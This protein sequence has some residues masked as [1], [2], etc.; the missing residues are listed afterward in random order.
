MFKNKN[1]FLCNRS[2]RKK[3]CIGKRERSYCLRG[4]NGM[5]LNYRH[6]GDAFIIDKISLSGNR[7]KLSSVTDR[8]A[9]LQHSSTNFTSK[10]FSS[11]VT[12]FQDNHKVS[13]SVIFLN[14]YQN[15]MDILNRLQ[16]RIEFT[17][18]SV[19]GDIPVSKPSPIPSA[20]QMVCTSD[21]LSFPSE[22]NVSK[23]LDQKAELDSE[24]VLKFFEPEFLQ[25]IQNSEHESKAI[26]DIS[27]LS[28]SAIEINN[29]NCEDYINCMAVQQ[30]LKQVAGRSEFLTE[31]E[32]NEAVRKTTQFFLNFNVQEQNKEKGSKCPASDR[33]GEPSKLIVEN[34]D[35]SLM[36]TMHC[37]SVT[38]S[39]SIHSKIIDI[40]N[41]H[42]VNSCVSS[43]CIPV[44][45]DESDWNSECKSNKHVQKDSET[46]DLSTELI[47]SALTSDSTICGTKDITIDGDDSDSEP[48]FKFNSDVSEMHSKNKIN[49]VENTI[50]HD[51]A[52]GTR[53][54]KN[55]LVH[56][57]CVSF[58]IPVD[59]DNESD[60]E[61][62]SID[63][64][65]DV[66]NMSTE[67]KT[68]AVNVTHKP[69]NAPVRSFFFR[70]DSSSS[71][72][73]S[74][75]DDD[76]D[77]DESCNVE[78]VDDVSEFE[79][80]G[81]YV[82]NFTMQRADASAFTVNP[83][84]EEL[85]MI[86]LRLLLHR[87]NTE[88]DE[89]TKDLDGKD[90]SSSKVSFAPDDKLVEVLPVEIYDR[91]GEWDII[92]LER[93]R[94]ERRIDEM[95]KIISPI[96]S[97]VHRRSIFLNLQERNVTVDNF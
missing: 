91:K 9:S 27:D 30:E 88:W 96:L 35:A 16:T 76:S 49:A 1:S 40:Q 86:K 17:T 72:S 52:N 11:P 65:S 34:S 61:S 54:P 31:S 90:K 66:S 44:N 73:E 75:T 87:V 48:D 32:I 56:T 15:M 57:E 62:E 67:A 78:Y 14:I 36:Y 42:P 47:V 94:F 4:N 22:V 97:K 79:F 45:G 89:A 2:L 60:W 28:Y 33:N 29:K 58:L 80:S 5:C 85:E 3:E 43:S 6:K 10:S 63:E 77:W 18:K 12:T 95:E 55:V 38:E 8:R 24:R 37:S 69:T 70:V 26:S 21:I 71:D 50:N 19:K 53:K 25:L 23:K 74:S 64:H 20:K 92:A 39:K 51:S 83:S 68:N 59:S 81:L 82:Q 93:I 13:D 84:P 7:Y 41:V 46:C